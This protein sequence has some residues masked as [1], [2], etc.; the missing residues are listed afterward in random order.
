VETNLR[1]ALAVLIAQRSDALL[2]VDDDGS[3]LGVVRR[4][5]LLR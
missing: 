4:E 2:V 5:D 1:E 3:P